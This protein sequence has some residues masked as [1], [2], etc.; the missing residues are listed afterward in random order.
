VGAPETGNGIAVDSNGCAYV[1]GA[2]SSA[3]FP[4][5]NPL[6]STLRGSQDA[7]VV[8]FSA[9][10]AA[11]VYGTYLGGSSID[12][13]TAIAVDFAGRAYVGG[14]TI[15]SDFPV[16]SATQVSNAGGYDGFVAVV[17]S[18]GNKLALATYIGG[19]AADGVYGIGLDRLA[20]IYVAV[21]TLSTNFPL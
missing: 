20:N 6:Q 17:E 3:N 7:F 19:T 16:A 5:V 8:K 14:Y 10:G 2:T 15:S 9:G 4:V 18:T 21:Q 13:G 12:I 1:A 11:L